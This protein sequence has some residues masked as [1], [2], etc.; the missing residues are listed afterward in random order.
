MKVGDESVIGVA[1]QS[2]QLVPWGRLLRTPQ[3]GKRGAS[4][5]AGRN[6]RRLPGLAA[7]RCTLNR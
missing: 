6:I 3:N 2:E 5:E 1:A 7:R 4:R